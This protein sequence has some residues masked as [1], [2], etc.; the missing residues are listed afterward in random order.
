[1]ERVLEDPHVR[2]P[3]ARFQS[4]VVAQT[5]QL[6]VGDVGLPYHEAT[7]MVASS[8]GDGETPLVRSAREI[9]RA[10]LTAVYRVPP[11]DSARLEGELL[12]WFDR[13]RRRPGAAPS[14]AALRMQLVSMA[15]RVA[16]IYW[17][18]QSGETPPADQRLERTLT[19]GPD[20]M[21]ME[22]EA[23]LAKK[24]SGGKAES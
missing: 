20:V 17:T 12:V 18:G 3:R 11:A 23:R 5:L 7:F 9:I 13:L 19:L 22:L 1:M 24:G 4:A 21:A 15:C 14:V 8:S 10:A 16:H 6:T 2:E